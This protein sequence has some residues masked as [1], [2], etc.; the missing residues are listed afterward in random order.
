MMEHAC[1]LRGYVCTLFL[2][3]QF[4]QSISSALFEQGAL[5]FHLH[6]TMQIMKLALT[7]AL[8]GQAPVLSKCLSSHPAVGTTSFACSTNIFKLS[9]HTSIATLRGSDFFF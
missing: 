3:T 8:L 7:A 1:E 5:H 6:W 9:L 4:S 2:V